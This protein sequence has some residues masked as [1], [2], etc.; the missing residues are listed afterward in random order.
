MDENWVL[1]AACRVG[2]FLGGL[3]R[4]SRPN[5]DSDVI[6]GVVQPRIGLALGG[7]FARGIAHAGVLRILEENQI[8]IHCITGVSAGAIVAAAYASGATPAEIALA[9]CAMRFGDVGRWQIARLGFVASER[10]QRF[11]QRLLK[12]HSFEQMRI[13]LGVLATDLSTG[14]PV[15][16][17]GSGA[18]FDPIRASCSY[19]GL[20]EPLP[21]KGRLLVDGAMSME[22]PAALA[23]QL[24]ATH[25]ISVHLPM[26]GPSGPP[27]NMF[28]VVNRCFQ[29]MQ[30]RSEDAW[31]RD[32]DVLIAPDVRG[33]DWDG[34]ARGP[35]LIAAGEAAATAA[36]PAIK[37]WFAGKPAT[38]EPVELLQQSVP[39][40]T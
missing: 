15:P 19:P 28:Q 38:T 1:K 3:R 33:V 8:R 9:G 40:E 34:F 16:F 2:G 17:F 13:P 7:G 35:Q 14:E 23:R 5:Q 22:I 31:R 37:E 21:L 11:L 6:E 39:Q 27:S 29:I 20:F 36:L 18:V 12:V 4:F 26:R 25:I 32:T 30:S 24:G 10:M